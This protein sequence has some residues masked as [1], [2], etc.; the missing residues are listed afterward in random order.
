MGPVDARGGSMRHAAN[1]TVSLW[2][3]VKIAT[4]ELVT[5]AGG[6]APMSKQDIERCVQPAA[7]QEV[8]VEVAMLE[9]QVGV[10]CCAGVLACLNRLYVYYRTPFAI[11]AIVSDNAHSC[12]FRH[13]RMVDARVANHL[14]RFS[15]SPSPARRG[16]HPKVDQASCARLRRLAPA[17]GSGVRSRVRTQPCRATSSRSCNC[18]S[19]AHAIRVGAASLQW[20]NGR[21]RCCQHSPSYHPAD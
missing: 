5:L 10:S 4:S 20:G 15:Y 17:M 11:I 9:P 8:I 19:G 21:A 13:C 3:H 12:D 7:T 18:C 16:S 1:R 2:R 6:R 14:Y